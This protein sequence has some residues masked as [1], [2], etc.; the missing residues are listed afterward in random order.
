MHPRILP[1]KINKNVIF[2]SNQPGSSTDFSNAAALSASISTKP[3]DIV[4]KRR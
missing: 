1:I 4:L 2:L 3:V